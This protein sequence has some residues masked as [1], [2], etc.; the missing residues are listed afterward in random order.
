MPRKQYIGLR[1][2]NHNKKTKSKCSY[3]KKRYCV[4]C[5]EERDIYVMYCFTCHNRYCFDFINLKKVCF[6]RYENCKS[7]DYKYD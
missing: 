7:C 6:G 3:C 4:I 2:E 5:Q 1:C